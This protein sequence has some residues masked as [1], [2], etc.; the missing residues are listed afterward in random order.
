MSGEAL[1]STYAIYVERSSVWASS[2][3]RAV[4]P[5]GMTATVMRRPHSGQKRGGSS[6]RPHPGHWVDGLPQPVQ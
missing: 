4:Q 3:H 5:V 6:A 1:R 2:R